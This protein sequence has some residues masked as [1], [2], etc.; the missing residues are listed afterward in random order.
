MSALLEVSD[1]KTYFFRKKQ[2]IPAVDGVDFSIEK[3]ETVALVGESGSGKSI[4]SLS[5]MGLVGSSGGKIMNGSIKLEGRDLVT[6]KEHELC[7]IRGNDISMIF[8]EP[9]T[10]LNPVLTIGEQITEVLI[11]HKK[12][13][14][15]EADKKA[16]E[17]L[18]L[19]GFSRAEQLMKDYP[20]R[21]SGGMRQRVMIAIALSCNPKL[22]IADEP[23]TALDVTIQAQVLELMKD[24]C[25]KFGTSILLITHDLGV[26]SEIADRV[27]VMY[28]GQVVEN[29]T[30]DELFDNPLH[31][32]TQGLL[33]SIPVID[34][35][36]EKLTAIKGNV[37]TPDNL[38]A[39]CRFAPRCPNAMDKCW[40]L[41]P[42]LKTRPDG[43]AVR[44][45]LYEEEE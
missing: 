36:I 31:P 19:V 41:Q 5:I 12:L 20:H 14:K 11:Y 25:D 32:Y 17:L 33:H 2:P 26:V 34:G 38:P 28:C 18:K 30:V 39:G 10:S 6:Y 3:G 8:Q 22:L 23:T 9:M 16:V 43:R 35:S 15:K 42:D 45:F 1:L 21:L 24:L 40:G 27:I 13:S 37:P 4:T 29:A 7:K 44:C